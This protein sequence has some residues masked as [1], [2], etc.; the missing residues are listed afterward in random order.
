MQYSIQGQDN[1]VVAEKKGISIGLSLFGAYPFQYAMKEKNENLF[2]FEPDIKI[3]VKN[4]EYAWIT[5]IGYANFSKDLVYNNLEYKLQGFYIKTGFESSL[6]EYLSSGIMACV[7]RINE[8]G[9]FIFEG[10][11]FDTY[12]VPFERTKTIIYMEP[13]F[14]LK[15]PVAKRFSI[16]PRVFLNL[17]FKSN[18][19]YVPTYYIPGSGYWNNFNYLNANFDL[20]LFYQL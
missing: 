8:S 12:K 4:G 16:E 3:P 13:Y 20:K 10:N 2:Y 5:S 17:F 15:I 19:K 1:P 7:T 9:N 18:D 6:F 14:T 11:Y